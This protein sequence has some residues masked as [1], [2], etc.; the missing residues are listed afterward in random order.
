MSSGTPAEPDLRPVALAAGAGPLPRRGGSPG[1]PSSM[2]SSRPG[3]RETPRWWRRSRRCCSRT[4]PRARSWTD[5]CPRSPAICCSGP[6]RRDGW[7]PTGCCVCSA[8]AG[9]ASS[10]SSS[11]RTWAAARRSSSS[12]TPGSHRPAGRAFS[13][14]SA[15]S[16]SSTTR[17]SLSCTTRGRC[18]TARPGSRWS[19]SRASPLTEYCRAQGSGLAERLRLFRAVCEAVQH[20]H[21]HAVIHRDLKPSNILVKADGAVKLLDF[22]IAKQLETTG[23]GDGPDAHRSAPD[24][25]GLRRARA[26]RGRSARRRDRRLRAGRAAL[27]AAHGSPPVRPHRP[28]APRGGAAGAGAGPTAAL[29]GRGSTGPGEPRR[30]GRPRRAR[31]DRHAARPGAAVSVGRGADPGPRPP[32]RRRAAGR[33]AGLAGLPRREAPAA[34]LADGARRVRRGA[35]GARSDRVLRGAA[36][37]GARRGGG[38]GRADPAHP[39]A[40]CSRSSRAGPERSDRRPSCGWWTLLDRGVREAQSLESEPAV[41]AELLQTL[42]GIAQALGRLDQAEDLL[43]P[44]AR[45]CRRGTFGQDHPDV[46]RSLVAG[47][48]A[49]P[50]PGDT[51][52]WPSRARQEGLAMLRRHRPADDPEVARA[53]SALGRSAGE[54]RQVP[55]CHP[56]ARGGG[57]APVAP[58]G[59]EA[60]LSESLTELANCHFYTGQYGQADALN[61]RVLAVD[62]RLHGPRHPHVADDLINLG[63]V[64]FESGRYRRPSGGTARRWRSSAAGTGRTIRRPPRPRPSSP[65]RC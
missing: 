62:R 42:G 53:T 64:Q 14:S 3:R 39:A 55:R 54:R 9:W 46:A 20:A 26:G 49:R 21:R 37:A 13:P 10:T 50:A 59:A 7:A 41:Q 52:T 40:S 17:A 8:R 44:R 60:D 18:P 2:L 16:R 33:A 29:P 30:V 12:A 25:P 5:R 38:R 45:R 43:E 31:P 28:A 63:A 58:S 57:P 61:Q 51:T 6:S 48:T 19:T 27:R 1:Y 65:A 22:G 47:G 32:P 34:E 56:C 35:G 15:R 36:G 23:S 11:E 24:D 4:G